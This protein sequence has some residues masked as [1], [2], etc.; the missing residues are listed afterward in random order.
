MLGPLN[1]LAMLGFWGTT[2]RLFT[3]RQGK[4]LF[5]LVDAGL[6]IGIIISCYTIPVLLSFKFESHNILLVS[7]SSVLVATI[8][9]ILIGARF[10]LVSGAS[11]QKNEMTTEKKSFFSVFREDRYTRIMGD[12]Y[13]S[14]GCNCIF[15]SVFI[16]GSYQ[17]TISFRGRYGKV[18]WNFYRQHDDI[19]TSC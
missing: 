13:C 9:Q 14:F 17:G 16:H 2:G 5:G 7:A 10:R 1:I 4:R 15:C 8:I 12:F 11:D 19:Y 3:L 18:P 6:I